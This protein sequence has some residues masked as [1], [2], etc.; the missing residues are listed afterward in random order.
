MILA[1]DY[2]MFLGARTGTVADSLVEPCDALLETLAPFGVKATFFVDCSYLER[3]VE[4]APAH[5]ILQS[6]LDA[7][8]RHLESLARAGH[9]L[10]LHLHPH[11]G[12]CTFDADSGWSVDHRRYRLHEWPRHEQVDMLR[13][14]KARLEAVAAEEVFAFRGGGWCIQPF[15]AIAPALRES[16]IWL[17]STV[18]PGGI[19]QDEGRQYDFRSVP[20]DA[21]WRFSSDP[22]VVDVSGEFVEVPISACTLNPL[23]F[24]RMAWYRKVAPSAQHRSFGS[25]MAIPHQMGYGVRR[26]LGTSISPVTIDGLKAG[27]LHNAFRQQRGGVFNVMGHPKALSRYSLRALDGFLTDHRTLR[28]CNF[29]DFRHLRPGAGQTGSDAGAVSGPVGGAVSKAL[30]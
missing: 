23:F 20:E 1:L 14:G 9:E 2:E 21:Y 10:Q 6:D 30:P 4:L 28:P 8:L 12:D 19:N 13:A 16:G 18:Y 15:D 27:E 24:L 5:R 26:L 3:L 25:G 11:W 29:R 7:I 22:L 17:D